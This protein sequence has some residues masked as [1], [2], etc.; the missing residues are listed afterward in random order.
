MMVG[1][2]SKVYRLYK[3]EKEVISNETDPCIQL[4]RNTW[5]PNLATHSTFQKLGQ[6][7]FNKTSYSSHR[8][9]RTDIC[10]SYTISCLMAAGRFHE[11]QVL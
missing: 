9:M 10:L 11:H 3:K 7:S 2:Q 4:L 1:I 6:C 5:A 8:R